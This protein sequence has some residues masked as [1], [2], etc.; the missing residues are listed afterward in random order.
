MPRAEVW[1]LASSQCCFFCK[2]V[3]G[4]QQSQSVQ[5]SVKTLAIIEISMSLIL[6]VAAIEGLIQA[7]GVMIRLPYE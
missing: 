4:S 2:S 5:P 7:Y 1:S 6:Q 3:I